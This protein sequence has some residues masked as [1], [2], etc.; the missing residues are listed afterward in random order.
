MRAT[1]KSAEEPRELHVEGTTFNPTQGGISGLSSLDRNIEVSNTTRP[2]YY[3][4]E[5]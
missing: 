4:L 2:C 5:N 3:M 1:G